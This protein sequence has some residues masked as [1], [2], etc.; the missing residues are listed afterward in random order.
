[1]EDFAAVTCIQ[2][3]WGGAKTYQEFD[4]QDQAGKNVLG[5]F[6]TL[7]PFGHSVLNDEYEKEEGHGNVTDDEFPGN[8]I[9]ETMEKDSGEGD[10]EIKVARCC[11]L[12]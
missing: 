1:M 10:F 7:K 2:V 8:T 12:L 5:L 4:D 11:C 3:A 9:L 6:W